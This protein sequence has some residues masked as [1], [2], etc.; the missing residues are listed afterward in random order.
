[1]LPTLAVILL[2]YGMHALFSFLFQRQGGYLRRRSRGGKL[3][4][5]TLVGSVGAGLGII[6]WCYFSPGKNDQ[7]LKL[8]GF[9]GTVYAE[10]WSGQVDQFK[11]PPVKHPNQA[12]GGQPVYALLH[13]GTPVRQVAPEKKLP[14]PRPSRVARKRPS[15][16]A[17]NNAGQTA[18][19]AKATAPRSKKGK[20]A[21]KNR[22]K[23]KK[24]SAVAPGRDAS[25][26]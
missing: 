12:S 25:A 21:G 11:Y 2:A 7:R 5:L 23:K 16:H 4:W 3:Y 26:G 9:L 24:Q 19:L 1:V 22:A 8:A 18:R 15:V 14:R 13:P 20:I 17:R 10:G 6:F